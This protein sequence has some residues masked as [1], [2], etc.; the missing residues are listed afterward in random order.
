MHIHLIT[1][2]SKQKKWEKLAFDDYKA[3]LPSKWR[4]QFDEINTIR[5]KK[6]ESTSNLV[7]EESKKILTKIKS[8][9]S[10]IV[11]D[12]EG[13]NFT[14]KELYLKLQLMSN[15]NSNLCFVIGGPDG[16]SEELKQKSLMK[17][18]LTNLTLPHGLAKIV[19]IEQIYR[20]WTLESHHPYHRD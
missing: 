8:N 14:T 6:N 1:V 11:L 20:L 13:E 4:F 2:S 10:I 9:E 15:V 18:S 16:I 3:R 17:W 12:E 19:F 5:R 7:K